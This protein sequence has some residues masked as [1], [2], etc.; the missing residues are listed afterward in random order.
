MLGAAMAALL[1]GVAGTATAQEVENFQ[2]GPSVGYS[3][4]FERAVAA[5]DFLVVMDR[6]F[7]AV[8]TI[9][10]ADV[11]SLRRW[12]VGAEL[13]WNAPAR[14]LHPKLL[15]WAGAGLGVLTEDPKGPVDPTTH[16]LV[17]NAVVG[18]GYDAPAAPFVQVRVAL[19]GPSDVALSVGVRF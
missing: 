3:S 10:Y 2:V 12:T 8:P 13:Q 7:S 1:L 17:S 4:R 11:G 15:A 5:V 6:N 19:E 14:R 16:D 9:S 18:V